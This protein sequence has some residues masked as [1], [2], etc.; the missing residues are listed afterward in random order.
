MENT[1]FKCAECGG[2]NIQVRAWVN[3]NTNEYIKDCDDD[4]FWCED[5]ESF[6]DLEKIKEEPEKEP[7]I[8]LY[9]VKLERPLSIRTV[10]I[11]A[12]SEEEAI[13]AAFDMYNDN[14]ILLFDNV[15]YEVIETK[16]ID[17]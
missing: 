10:D 17:Y 8:K 13:N 5:C 14:M 4:E 7:I 3:M 2:F 11:Q 12:S 1:K 6:V 15:D 16:D 9:T